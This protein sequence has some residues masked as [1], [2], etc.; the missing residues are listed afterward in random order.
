MGRT[1]VTIGLESKA[2]AA[3]LGELRTVVHQFLIEQWAAIL[4]EESAEEARG[5]VSVG[6]DSLLTIGDREADEDARADG[7]MFWFYRSVDWPRD[8][9]E[10]YLNGALF[11]GRADLSD[12][13]ERIGYRIGAKYPT[14][15]MVLDEHDSLLGPNAPEPVPAGDCPICLHVRKH[16][17][18]PVPVPAVP[19]PT[20]RRRELEKLRVQI[21]HANVV[22][23]NV[24]M[25]QDRAGSYSPPEE[26]AQMEAEL[27]VATRQRSIATAALD[28]LLTRTREECP[29]EIEGWALAHE[30]LVCWYLNDCA[31]RGESDSL[32]AF[33][34]SMDREAWAAVRAGGNP[35]VEEKLSSTSLN[36]ERYRAHFGIDPR[37]LERVDP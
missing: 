22:A 33:S 11:I 18:D 29:T 13:L 10:H 32:A 14:R 20:D 1:S 6:S 31:E 25:W 23:S 26:H 9:A 3:P 16:F 27:E 21:H 17:A 37:T 4:D 30:A 28:E 5:W 8:R 7:L 12:A 19:P 34:A 15:A 2:D 35:R 24:S 36:D